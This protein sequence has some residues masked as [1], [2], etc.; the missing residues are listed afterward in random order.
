MT[1]PA[2]LGLASF[3]PAAATLASAALPA[4]L[5]AGAVP[6]DV[7]VAATAALLLASLA[8]VLGFV[9]LVAGTCNRLSLAARAAWVV[10]LA[11][12]GTFAAPAFWLFHLRQPAGL[13]TG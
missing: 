3:L 5:A 8:V 10:A 9:W 11:V 6:P 12:F 4:A 13:A 1:R 2:A 7:V